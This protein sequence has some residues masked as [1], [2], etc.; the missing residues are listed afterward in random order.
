MGWVKEN[1]LEKNQTVKGIILAENKNI[2][3]DFAINAVGDLVTFKRINLSV[4]IE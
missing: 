4:T 3:L 2:H 1:L